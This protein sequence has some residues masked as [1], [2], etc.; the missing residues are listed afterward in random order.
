MY[1]LTT[2]YISGQIKFKLY[3]KY[4]DAEKELYN[5]AKI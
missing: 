3:E 1:R 5:K 4:K 2:T